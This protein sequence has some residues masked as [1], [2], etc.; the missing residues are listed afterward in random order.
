LI[1]KGRRDRL[2]HLVGDSSS[3]RI[4][5]HRLCLGDLLL[6]FRRNEVASWLLLR[7]L[8][9]SNGDWRRLR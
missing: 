1:G 7:S 6:N 9:L 3:L 4:S 5:L 2:L 8:F